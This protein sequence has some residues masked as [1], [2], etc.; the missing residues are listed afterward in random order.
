MRILVFT[1]TAGYRHDSIPGGLRHVTAWPN[2]TPGDGPCSP[3]GS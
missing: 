1:R 2:D 3:A